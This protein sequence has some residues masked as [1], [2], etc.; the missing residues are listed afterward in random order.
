MKIENLDLTKFKKKEDLPDRIKDQYENV[1]GGFV[2]K[3]VINLEE[4]T[5]SAAIANA[6]FGHKNG[7]V[8]ESLLIEGA[9]IEDRA[10]EE[11]KK[12]NLEI[13]NI[14]AVRDDVKIMRDLIGKDPTLL[15]YASD[16]IRS[17]KEI[18][19]NAV[20]KNPL[21]LQYIPESL[22][23][24]LSKIMITDDV[25]DKEKEK[26]LGYLIEMVKDVDI[27]KN[28]DDLY[29]VLKKYGAKTSFKP[30]VAQDVIDSVEEIEQV[31][32]GEKDINELKLL[33]FIVYK[34]KNLL[35]SEKQ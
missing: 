2:K 33:N 32:N 9:Q 19:L 8:S 22:R 20:S 12:G 13:R 14:Y 11:I 35:G 7:T 34:V 15:R 18:V 21:V 6:F 27:A 30:F 25:D 16:E 28:F 4:R 23:K 31:R 3:E 24:E 29:D 17:N 5:K 10:R 1:E 26:G